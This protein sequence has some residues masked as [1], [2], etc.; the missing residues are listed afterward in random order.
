ME[1]IQQHFVCKT[2]SYKL[3]SRNLCWTNHHYSIS[4][5]QLFSI[6]SLHILSWNC[7][8]IK[9]ILIFCDST[10]S[11]YYPVNYLQ[12]FMSEMYVL[13]SRNSCWSWQS[14]RTV[15]AMFWRKVMTWSLMVRSPRRRSTRSGCRW[16]CWTTDGRT[17]DW[18]PCPGRAS[19]WS[20][21]CQGSLRKFWS[22]WCWLVND[23]YSLAEFHCPLTSFRLLIVQPGLGYQHIQ[24]FDASTEQSYLANACGLLVWYCSAHLSCKNIVRITQPLTT[25][26]QHN[27]FFKFFLQINAFNHQIITWT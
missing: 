7:F 26:K 18:K 21:R 25:Y 19:E 3:F 20:V 5:V 8:S 16:A 22:T 17:S 15:L 14:T 13:F 6:W 9:P 4:F 1:F 23:K 12:E 11:L 2:E 24:L 10:E 27:W